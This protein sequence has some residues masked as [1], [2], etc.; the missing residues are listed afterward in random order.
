[1]TQDI[2]LNVDWNDSGQE[3]EKK[4]PQAIKDALSNT[5]DRVSSLTKP[6]NGVIWEAVASFKLAF[7]KFWTTEASALVEG[8]SEKRAAN[9]DNYWENN[10]DLAA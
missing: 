4:Q 5:K 2:N 7:N 1:M 6:A 8:L 10:K 9:D 3:L